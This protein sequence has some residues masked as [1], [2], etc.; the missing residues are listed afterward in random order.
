MVAA[1]SL[2]SPG[3]RSLKYCTKFCERRASQA[4]AVN[5]GPGT[6]ARIP[7][8]KVEPPKAGLKT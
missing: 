6:Q 4:R 3:E 1:Y 8:E 2:P 7:E 5:P